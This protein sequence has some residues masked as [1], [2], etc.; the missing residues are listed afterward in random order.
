MEQSTKTSAKRL[1]LLAELVAHVAPRGER[2]A[3]RDAARSRDRL[4][5]EAN[6]A[7]DARVVLA[8]VGQPLEQRLD[9]A[10]LVEELHCAPR[11]GEPVRYQLR[12]RA[13]PC[14]LHA[15]KPD[16]EPGRLR[17]HVPSEAVPIGRRRRRRQRDD[18]EIVGDYIHGLAGCQIAAP[19]TQFR[20]VP[21]RQMVG[22]LSVD[23]GPAGAAREP[24]RWPAPRVRLA[25]GRPAVP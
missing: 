21:W 2:R 12:E 23:F 18:R 6:P 15:R 25:S 8:R 1:R 22:Q 11:R 24:R 17:I 5:D 3:D 13:L 4:R 9:V 10:V 7:H 19:L 14:A 16:D 20:I